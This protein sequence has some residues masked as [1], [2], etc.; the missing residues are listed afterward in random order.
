VGGGIFAVLGVAA[1]EARGATP[2]AFA[3]A[4]AVAALTAASYSRLST[5]FQSAGGTVTF[6]DRAFGISNL[7]GALNIVL[8]AGYIATTA[9]Y[10]SAFANYAATF[11]PGGGR[12]GP[13]LL[14]V[15]VLVGVLIPW[16]INLT[17]ARL[18]AKSESYI[19]VTKL[20]ILAVVIAAGT[21][22]LSSA[23]LAPATTWPPLASVLAAGMLIFVAYEGFEL[24]ANASADI[25]RPERNLPLA[26]GLSVGL[27]LAL[28]VAIAAVVVG[29]LSP[30]RIAADADVAL[31]V[32]AG[33]SLGHAGFT[34]VA[35]SAL[36][37][38]LSATNATLYGA[39]RLSFTLATEGEL[40]LAF[41]RKEWNQPIGLHVTALVGLAL[42]IGLPLTSL[43]TVCSA[44][45]LL[46]FAVVNAAAFRSA[47]TTGGGRWV[48]G[49]GVLGCAGSLVALLQRSVAR[50][51]VGLIVLAALIAS[52]L[53]TEH[54][55]LRRRRRAGSS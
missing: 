25:R 34:L 5:R 2:I 51:P 8:W 15:L 31:A 53:A 24:I 4:G 22:S 46:V 28:Y 12:P 35:I 50:D 6:V 26:F 43:S 18:V 52:A 30:E 49:L 9:L 39:A 21:P 27:V 54:F 32:A 1:A 44:I 10:V 20:A 7:T 16:V 29:S 3:V 38:T 33:A 19:V 41:E 11:A 55:V 40:T 37:A 17:S 48:P 36:L 42:A 23:R 45:F 13:L 14:R 47:T